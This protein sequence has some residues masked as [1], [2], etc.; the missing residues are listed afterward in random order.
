MCNNRQ[1]VNHTKYL[2]FLAINNSIIHDVDLSF[3]HLVC[4]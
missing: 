4:V 1:N 2:N 3:A